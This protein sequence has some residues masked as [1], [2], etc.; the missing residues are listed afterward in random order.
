MQ[1]VEEVYTTIYRRAPY[2]APQSSGIG[3]LLAW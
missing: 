3:N 2:E 1:R